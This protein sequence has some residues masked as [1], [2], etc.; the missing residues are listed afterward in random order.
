[1]AMFGSG[2]PLQSS[3]V[4]YSRGGEMLGAALIQIAYNAGNAISAAV[5]GSVIRAGYGYT[6]PALAGIPFVAFGTIPIFILYFRR[7]RG[8]SLPS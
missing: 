6:Y 4:G 8:R 2:S 3:I 1:M 5:G 7:E